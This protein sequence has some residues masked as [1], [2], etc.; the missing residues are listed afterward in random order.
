MRK[1]KREL[2]EEHER[3]RRREVLCWKCGGPTIKNED[4]D[5]ELAAA[6]HAVPEHSAGDSNNQARNA[7][8]HENLQLR[9]ELEEKEQVIKFMNKFAEEVKGKADDL[10]RVTRIK[11]P[12]RDQVTEENQV[13]RFKELVRELLAHSFVSAVT[14]DVQKNQ[15]KGLHTRVFEE[16]SMYKQEVISLKVQQPPA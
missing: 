7:L 11:L 5:G 13:D 14:S 16:R 6:L 3:E 10:Q 8:E 15:T 1:R 12:P 9:A 4:D 2:N